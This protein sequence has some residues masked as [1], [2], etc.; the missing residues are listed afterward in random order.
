[1]Q[2]A[3]GFNYHLLMG[4]WTMKVRDAVGDGFV[5]PHVRVNG[6]EV[7]LDQTLLFNLTQ[8]F[9]LDLVKIF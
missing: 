3:E 7:G 9:D 2:G 1:M 5:L 8:I 4:K 6:K